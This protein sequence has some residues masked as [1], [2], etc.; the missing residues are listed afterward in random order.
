MHSTTTH[1]LPLAQPR[2]IALGLL[3]CLA[4][5]ADG[6][7]EDRPQSEV[8][9][10]RTQHFVGFRSLRGFGAPPIGQNVVITDRGKLNLFA[11][12]TY[13]V[14]RG[15]QT[16][17]AELYALESTGALSLFLQGGGTEPSVVFL[18]GYGLFDGE[19]SATDMFFTDRVSTPASPSLGLFVSTRVATGQVELEGDW[20][21]LSQ[22]AIF[23][24]TIL[25]PDNVGRAA[26]G[27]VDI[28]A[29]AAGTVRAIS[30]TG[31]QSQATQGQGPIT[32]GGTIQNVLVSG[33]GD[34]TCNMTL[35]YGADSRI[36]LAVATGD[37]TVGKLLIGLDDEENETDGEAGIVLMVREFNGTLDPAKVDGRF[38]VG[39]HT[40]FVNPTNAGSDAFVGVVTLGDVTLSEPGAFRLDAVGNQG[41]DFTY[42]GTYVLLPVGGGSAD[43]DGGIKITIPGTNETWFAAIDRSYNTLVFVDDF[44]EARNNPELNIG[45]A[46]REKPDQN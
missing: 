17:G 26:H 29:G 35:Q 44:I 28:A 27:S 30:G 43:L 39:G 24:Q 5:C 42:T 23:N 3:V 8:K 14:T 2:A 10:S 7:K 40:L 20:H 6:G 16:T 12:S 9:I 38:L 45:F 18:G 13:T 11:D 22:H 41:I 46:V 15:A 31:T 21:V 32:F 36:V 19:T 4:A 34:G 33:S 37:A 1:S 25:T